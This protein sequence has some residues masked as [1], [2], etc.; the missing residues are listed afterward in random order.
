MLRLSAIALFLLFVPAAPASNTIAGSVR[1]P[2]RGEP[3]A[4]DDVILFRLRPTMHDEAH[5][6]TDAQG[7]F[8]LRARDSGGP[9][10][11]RVVH[12]NV[13]YDTAA[14]VGDTL[15]V[16][17]FDAAADV[18]DVKATV[19]MLRAGAQGKLLHV[20]DMYEVENTSTPPMTQAGPHTFEVDLPPN[21]RLDSVLAAG[22]EK[23]VTMISATPVSGDPGHYRVNF[24]LRPGATRFAFNYDLPYNG[25]AAFQIRHAYPVQQL[26]V[27]IPST[28]QFFSPSSRFQK[29]PSGDDNY[30]VL[31][32][33][34]LEEGDGPRFELSGAGALP[35]LRD[36]TSKPE[37]SPATAVPD[38]KEVAESVAHPLASPHTNAGA[39]TRSTAA[40]PLWAAIGV[41]VVF[42]CASIAGRAGKI[43]RA[44]LY[45]LPPGGAIPSQVPTAGPGGVK[46]DLF[47]LELDRIRGSISEDEYASLREAL[48]AA[49]K[50]TVV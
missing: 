34:Q 8:V 50:R 25:H 26:V 13:N 32:M 41:I 30:R 5:A 2:S 42:V 45:E 43:R 1:N 40:W 49:V 48:E 18:P 47:R 29:L 21:A 28:M 9:Y 19:E 20:S 36:H 15:S 22:P 14:S 37:R 46:D 16:S 23:L 12:Q 3:A 4:G 38:S 6:K 39:K 27:M 10:L 35:H 24:P 44:P 7:Q 17:V 11:V 33:N 31:A